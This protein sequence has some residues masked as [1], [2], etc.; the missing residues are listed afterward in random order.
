MRI[1]AGVCV[2]YIYVFFKKKKLPDM[3]DESKCAPYTLLCVHAKY[4]ISKT[5]SD[6]DL[7]R[8]QTVCQVDNN[9]RTSVVVGQSVFTV[10][11]GRCNGDIPLS[12]DKPLF[13]HKERV[14]QAESEDEMAC[15]ISVDGR[16]DPSGIPIVRL[17]ENIA[18]LITDEMVEAAIAFCCAK[19]AMDDMRIRLER[20][21]IV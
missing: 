7:T 2:C 21:Q 1:R 16:L 18:D 11:K 5:P 20:T 9:R 6:A 4:Y 17:V 3:A 13:Y 14:F 12:G 8:V 19:S 10:T 15:C